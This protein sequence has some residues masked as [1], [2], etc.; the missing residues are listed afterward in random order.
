GPALVDNAAGGLVQLPLVAD[1]GQADAVAP[2][3]RP[4]VHARGETGKEARGQVGAHQGVQEVQGPGAAAGE[5]AGGPH[6]VV[7]ELAGHL[8]DPFAGFRTDAAVAVEGQGGGG[9]GNASLLGDFTNGAHGRPPPGIEPV[10]SSDTNRGNLPF[11][12]TI[13]CTPKSS[14]PWARRPAHG[15]RH[16]LSLAL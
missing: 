10:R 1:Q 3:R 16:A 13:R 5:T 2:L 14:S 4:V 15:P 7:V 6:G 9:N 11:P 8:E 12:F